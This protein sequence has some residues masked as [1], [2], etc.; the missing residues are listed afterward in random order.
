MDIYIVSLHSLLYGTWQLRTPPHPLGPSSARAWISSYGTALATHLY[1]PSRTSF[2]DHRS[3]TVWPGF[4][5][6]WPGT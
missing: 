5:I 3:S 6:R 4:S 2:S 1:F